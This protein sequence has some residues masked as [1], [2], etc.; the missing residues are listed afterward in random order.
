[1]R[2]VTADY[3]DPK[4]LEEVLERYL[5]LG[6]CPITGEDFPGLLARVMVGLLLPD[7]STLEREGI[8]IQQTGQHSFLVQ[9]DTP[10]DTGY[11]RRFLSR[12]SAE[13]PA[14]ARPGGQEI[15]RRRGSDTSQSPPPV[16]GKE[17]ETSD[18]YARI[19]DLPLQEK[20]KLARTGR[21][22]ARQLLIRDVNKTLHRVVLSNPDISV[23]EVAEYAASPALAKD[24]LEYIT[25]NRTWMASRQVTFA[26][27]KNPSTPVE[28]AVRLVPRLGQSEWRYL[29]RPGAVRAPVAAQA[30]K[31][32]L[33]ASK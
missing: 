2:T 29:A 4:R 6:V 15:P 13:D 19:R 14:V 17:T 10:L 22:P 21:K 27:V 5:V 3:S 12:G 25:Q 30:R 9:L 1:M 33:D 26:V 11:L 24:A 20:Q 7:S 31:Q 16:T 28:I 18:L 23:D 8:A 32:I